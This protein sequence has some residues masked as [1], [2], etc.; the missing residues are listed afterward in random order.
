MITFIG[1][2]WLIVALLLIGII[3]IQKGKGGG[4]GGAFGGAG[5]GGGLL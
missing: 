3:L 5:G 4:L 2:V 1:I